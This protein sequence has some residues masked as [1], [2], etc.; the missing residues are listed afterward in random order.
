MKNIF[1]SIFCILFLA[2]VGSSYAASAQ[3][4]SNIVA[5][6]NVE[7]GVIEISYD[8]DGQIY[9]GFSL[10][11]KLKQLA[12]NV[13]VDI[14][15]DNISP[16]LELVYPGT[17][18]KFEIGLDG[19]TLEGEFIAVLN[20]IPIAKPKPVEEP[21]PPVAPAPVVN[22]V[23]VASTPEAPANPAPA[24]P[25]PAAEPAKAK[26]YGKYVRGFSVSGAS[27]S[28]LGNQ[29]KLRSE[30]FMQ[31]G[32]LQPVN[33]RLNLAAQT[34]SCDFVESETGFIKLG[35]YFGPEKEGC[36]SCERVLDRNPS[37]KI[38]RETSFKNYVFNLIAIHN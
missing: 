3:T 13:L 36:I 29:I 23:K 17:R 27:W 28:D 15:A 4:I 16:S 18:K 2:F 34:F 37:S 8:L 9:Q 14:P 19:L 5:G 38:L 30:E 31:A 32:N 24:N 33:I 25:A 11:V 12:D 35:L 7:K 22:E 1:T 6:F 26:S 20:A 10:S 21:A